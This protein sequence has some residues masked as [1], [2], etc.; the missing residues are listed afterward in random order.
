MANLRAM[1]P[2]ATDPDKYIITRWGKEENVRGAY[3][4]KILGRDFDDDV[5]SLQWPLDNSVWFAGEAMSP[6]W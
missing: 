2:T 6:V 4:F 3:S 1:F 5:E